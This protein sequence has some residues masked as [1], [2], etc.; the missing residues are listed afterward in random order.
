MRDNKDECFQRNSI[1]LCHHH[2]MEICCVKD[3]SCPLCQ[4]LW[5]REEMAADVPLK[6]TPM[7]PHEKRVI[8]GVGLYQSPRK[9]PLGQSGPTSA[10][11]LL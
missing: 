9:S 3:P 7:G 2:P 1:L 10:S 11:Y 6:I 4:L 8:P 5:V